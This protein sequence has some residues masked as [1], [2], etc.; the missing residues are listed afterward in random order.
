MGMSAPANRE[1]LLIRTANPAMRDFRGIGA[2]QHPLNLLYLAT[3]LNANGVKASVYDL[4]VEPLE[5][6]RRRLA[7]T[8]PL[9]GGVTAM[10][11]GIG[12]AAEV[13]SLLKAAG[14][15]TVVGGA[16]ATALPAETLRDTGA[17]FVITGEG[18]R[19]LLEL[20]A[21]LAASSPFENI[22]GLAF[23]RDGAPVVNPRPGPLD[24]DSLPVPDRSLL[25]L[26]LYRGHTTPG[27]PS[28]GAML[29]T[30]RGCPFACAYCA[31]R[32]VG[33]G[34][35]RL[36]SIPKVL[37]EVDYLAGLGFTHITVD[38]DTLTLDRRRVLAFCAGM[39]ARRGLTWNCTSRADAMDRELTEAMRDA[40]CIKIAFGVE[41]GSQRVLDAIG[42]KIT[43]AQARECFRLAREAG[44]PAQ[45]FFMV[46]HPEETPEDIA[47]TETLIH[48]LKPDLLFLSLASPLPGTRYHEIFKRE[49]WLPDVPWRDY[50]FFPESPAWRTRHFTGPE[51]TALRKS[52][53]RRYYFSPAFI[54]RRLAGLRRPGELL[55]L[56]KGAF[57]ALRA[58]VLPRRQKKPAISRPGPGKY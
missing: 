9:L 34:R 42:K 55:Y 36:R 37:E 47:A 48:E 53:S 10:T 5:G 12:L 50:S 46:G 17:D 19:P 27:V 49:G 6:L 11:T 4:E 31:S 21:A 51:L 16:H 38:D 56:L 18:E 24:L 7:E 35:V 54:L 57:A 39:K 26:E 23:T 44:L 2:S 25:R 1:V 43:V 8:P 41:S 20:A 14:A 32:V 28:G 3:Y 33:G 22:A 52:I 40:G 58:F 29:F 45:A 15:R 30:A 13:C